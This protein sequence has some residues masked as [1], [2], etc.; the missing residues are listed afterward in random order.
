MDIK[1]TLEVV[2]FVKALGEKME[3]VASD[4]KVTLME[5]LSQFPALVAPGF[6]AI[7]DAQMVA[8]ELKELDANEV[9][10][11]VGALLD[12]IAPFVKLLGGG[13]A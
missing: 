9:Q 13:K 4:G 11:L 3:S 6:T 2:G 10:Q 7:K 5:V 12:A 8:Q 1:E